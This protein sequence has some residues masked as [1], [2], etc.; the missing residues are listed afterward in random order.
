G[1]S[2]DHRQLGHDTHLA[3]GSMFSRVSLTPF[4]QLQDIMRKGLAVDADGKGVYTDDT[5]AHRLALPI[6][7]L[8]GATN[9]IFSPESGQRT[10]AWLSQH[11]G[12]SLYRQ[13]I[14]PGYGHMDLFIGRNAHRD[15]TPLIVEELENLDQITQTV[16]SRA[17]G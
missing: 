9:Q 8:S 2:W 6:T 12:K 17:T 14:I 13:R 3:L 7:F 11:N 10:R 1:P 16:A 15:V 5:A 4:R